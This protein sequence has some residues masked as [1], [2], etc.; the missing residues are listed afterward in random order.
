MFTII[1]YKKE[2]IKIM[3]EGMY[4]LVIAGKFQELLEIMRY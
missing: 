1:K 2:G 4:S 3:E